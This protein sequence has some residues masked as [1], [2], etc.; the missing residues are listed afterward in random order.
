MANISNI[1]CP[2]NTF[3]RRA[4]H[5]LNSLHTETCQP[6]MKIAKF[7]VA[8]RHHFANPALTP[9]ESKKSTKQS[10][11]M[12]QDLNNKRDDTDSAYSEPTTS[13][14]AWDIEPESSHILQPKDTEFTSFPDHTTH[15]P[16]P[17]HSPNQQTTQTTT[18]ATYEYKMQPKDQAIMHPNS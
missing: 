5:Y 9:K 11:T 7:I 16:R 4:L 12:L 6:Q 10:K 17:P 3:Y 1:Q 2:W 15:L 13:P 8:T 14:T 18:Q